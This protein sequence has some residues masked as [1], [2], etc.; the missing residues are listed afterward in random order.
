MI[1]VHRIYETFGTKNVPEDVLEDFVNKYNAWH[2]SFE[3]F[4]R[5]LKTASRA[6]TASA[7]R[8]TT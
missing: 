1:D 2:N 8:W 3:W 6:R 4:V 7:A 5:L